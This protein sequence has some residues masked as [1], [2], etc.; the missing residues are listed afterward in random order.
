MMRRNRLAVA[1]LI[2]TALGASTTWADPDKI[3]A[4][5]TPEKIKAAETLIKQFSAREFNVRQQAVEKLV[6]LGPEIMPLLKKAM[7][8][9]DDP[10][11]KLRGQMAIRRIREKYNVDEDGKPIKVPD[12]KPSRITINFKG[13]RLDTLMR[14]FAEQ[15]GNSEIKVADNLKNRKIDFEVK[16]MPYWDALDKACQQAGVI[17]ERD[18]QSKKLQLYKIGRGGPVM[19]IG[20]NVGPAAIK[21][22]QATKSRAFRAR[23]NMHSNLNYAYTFFLEDRLP[24][25]RARARI[26]RAVDP[27][28]A[29]LV[30]Q[31]A[32]RLLDRWSGA[33]GW[34]GGHNNFYINNPPV[35]LI[36][37]AE[38]EGVV[39]LE[40]GIG[41]E[42]AVI[43]DVL[44]TKKDGKWLRTEELTLTVTEASRQNDGFQ[45]KIVGTGPRSVTDS[46]KA[47][48]GYG[49]FLVNPSGKRFSGNS[50]R[51]S[52]RGGNND[53]VKFEMTLH[54]KA[55]EAEGAWSMLW[56]YPE[57]T[58]SKD[59]PFKLHNVPLP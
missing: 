49:L 31:H 1:L 2:L 24:V 22:T 34:T 10:E 52:T 55:P 13:I 6:E 44:N 7:T 8:E 4:G 48:S 37:I 25:V 12:F 29:E 28:G 54:Y 11:L 39:Q 38:M 43:K 50:R 33:G 18:W 42:K 14:L 9:N 56:L 53:Q 23:H 46:F 45:L 35:D 3:G 16:D 26:T 20:A 19:A 5:L 27:N 51:T 36:E 58:I 57:K 15:T 17:Y 47:R 41:Q 32:A 30:K 59:I 40:L 21:I